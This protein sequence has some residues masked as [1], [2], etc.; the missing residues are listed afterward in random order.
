M[1]SELAP[2]HHTELPVSGGVKD[3]TSTE[4][5]AKHILP[6]DIAPIHWEGDGDGDVAGDT[7]GDVEAE[8]DGVTDDD[9]EPEEGHEGNPI[10]PLGLGESS[11]HPQ[12]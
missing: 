6:H 4:E 10:W 3:C 1:H 2:G 12:S 11:C 7:L 9:S 5:T 8:G